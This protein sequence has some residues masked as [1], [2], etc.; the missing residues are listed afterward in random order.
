MVRNLIAEATLKKLSN[1]PHLG[2]PDGIWAQERRFDLARRLLSRESLFHGPLPAE[3]VRRR[4]AETFEL[5]GRY[6]HA[7]IY[8][9]GLPMYSGAELEDLVAWID[10]TVPA[11]VLSHLPEAD[12]PRP[13]GGWVWDVYSPQ[14][15][16]EFEAEVHWRACDGYDEALA[17][18]FARLGWSMP[19][20]AFAPFGVVLTLRLPGAA[21]AGT[22]PTLH[23]M[24]VPTALM[25]E[26]APPG[27]TP[28]GRRPGAR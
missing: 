26:L 9:G 5:V 2:T 16:M 15:L 25:P 24:R 18:V 11:A 3:D 20:S 6:P 22:P 4:A 23:A 19:A 17:H 1:D 10:A 28:S 14:R 13:G 21:E 7:G 12:V 8:F 27:P